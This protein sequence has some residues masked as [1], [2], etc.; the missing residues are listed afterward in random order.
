MWRALIQTGL[1][2]SKGSVHGRHSY[3]WSY[4]DMIVSE[5][6]SARLRWEPTLAFAPRWAEVHRSDVLH[7][8]GGRGRVIAY[9]PPAS[10]ATFAAMR[11]RSWSATA[12]RR[13]LEG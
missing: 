11:P 7:L 5:M 3:H 10:N 6:A 8:S 13:V 1:S 9:L 12:A 4:D 2:P